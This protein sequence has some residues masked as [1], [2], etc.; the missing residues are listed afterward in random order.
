MCKRELP[1]TLKERFSTAKVTRCGKFFK[2]L[3]ILKNFQKNHAI[4]ID[5]HM[6]IL[7]IYLIT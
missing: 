6:I 4:P 5:N 1:F 3:L 7:Y 2:K